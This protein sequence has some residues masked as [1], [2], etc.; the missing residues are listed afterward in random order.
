MG[1]TPPQW[2]DTMS[3]KD[4]IEKVM[5]LDPGVTTY[6]DPVLAAAI[7]LGCDVTS[8]YAAQQIAMPGF[9]FMHT[10]TNPWHSD[11]NSF[12]G[13]NSVIARYFVKTL[14][15]EAIHGEHTFGGH[16]E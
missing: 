6:A 16:R 7:G 14:N 5:G 13:G 11:T 8:A 10:N 1:R 4:Y 3:Y 15:P 12:P 9:A 2:L